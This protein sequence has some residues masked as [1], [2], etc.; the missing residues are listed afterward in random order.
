M[1]ISRISLPLVTV[2]EEVPTVEKVWTLY[3]SKSYVEPPEAVTLTTVRAELTIP[4]G[5]NVIQGRLLRD[6][7]W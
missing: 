6:T 7:D 2:K 4:N 3:P 5:I 1:T